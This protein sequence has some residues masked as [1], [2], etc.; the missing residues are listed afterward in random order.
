MVDLFHRKIP[1]GA[2][3]P[4]ASC[5]Y[6]FTDVGHAQVQKRLPNNLDKH[7]EHKRTTITHCNHAGL[8]ESSHHQE[9]DSNRVSNSILIPCTWHFKNMATFPAYF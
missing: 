8:G 3:K 7:S 1:K 4:P 9:A 6:E 2:I 5:K